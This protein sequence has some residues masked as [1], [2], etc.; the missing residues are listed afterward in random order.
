MRAGAYAIAEAARVSYSLPTTATLSSSADEAALPPA[1]ASANT[2]SKSP[3]HP[4]LLSQ[5]PL[6]WD[7][8]T[9]MVV[10]ALELA[11]EILLG[12]LQQW[13]YPRTTTGAWV[14]QLSWLYTST[15]S[16]EISRHCVSCINALDLLKAKSDAARLTT[17]H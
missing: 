12:W 5:I 8:H 13:R 9:E 2:N 15:S 14:W 6:L 10:K 3:V 11:S 17:Q 7:P 16:D 4:V 1:G